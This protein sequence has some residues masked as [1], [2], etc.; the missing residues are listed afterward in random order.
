MYFLLENGGLPEHY[1]WLEGSVESKYWANRLPWSNDMFT[2]IPWYIGIHLL[3]RHPIYFETSSLYS[4]VHAYTWYPTHLSIYSEL[5]SVE[6]EIHVDLCSWT[7]APCICQFCLNIFLYGF[8]PIFIYTLLYLYLEV[9]S[10][11][12]KLMTHMMIKHHIQSTTLTLGRWW[13]VINDMA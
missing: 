5:C 1:V 6:T 12:A 13:D 9:C 8:F 11:R 2:E 3:G 7:H 4:F 10:T